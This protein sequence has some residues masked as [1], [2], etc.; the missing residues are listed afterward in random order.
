MD[1]TLNAELFGDVELNFEEMSDLVDFSTLP[2]FD[3]D[4]S[5]ISGQSMPDTPMAPCADMGGPCME[6]ESHQL[7]PQALAFESSCQ[8]TN[9]A[10]NA[11]IM[12]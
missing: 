9:T 6:S 3:F 5:T 10:D 4:S 2:P 11:K 7:N 8:A 1:S 12:K